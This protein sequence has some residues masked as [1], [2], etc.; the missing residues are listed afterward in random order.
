MKTIGL[1]GGTSPQSTVDYYIEIN[2]FIN[3]SLGNYHSA[4]IL[5]ISLDFQEIVSAI[6]NN[7]WNDVFSI[8]QEAAITLQSAGAEALALCSNTLH[9]V[10]QEIVDSVEIP[11]IHILDPVVNTIKKNNIKT[12][13]ILGTKYTVREKFHCVYLEERLNDVNIIKPDPASIKLID[14]IIFDSLCKGKCSQ[15]DLN[16]AL[17]I[18]HKLIFEKKA[19]VILLACTELSH[20]FKKIDIPSQF[21]MDTTYLHSKELSDFILNTLRHD[22]A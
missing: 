2:D 18:A 17:N 12:V 19:D 10:Y 13:A 3:K 4:K 6:F 9:K 7:R 16:H 8:L 20:L 22:H 1:I 11:V 5:M 21:I 14:K 15:S